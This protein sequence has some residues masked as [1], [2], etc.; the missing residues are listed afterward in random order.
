MN[1]W[2]ILFKHFDVILAG[3]YK[4][5]ILF[6]VSTISAGIIGIIA[7]FLLE[8]DEK[9]DFRRFLLWSIDI[10]RMLPFLI[11]VYLLYYGLPSLGVRMDAWTVGLVGLALY[12]GAY[13][14]EILRGLR[15]TLPRGQIDAAL[16][17]GYSKNKM[18][19]YL[20]LPQ[21]LLKSAPLMGNQLIYL[22]KDTA[23]LTIITV[24]ELTGAAASVQSIY[25]IPFQAFVVAI[26]F[27]WIVSIT[28]E[29]SM[30]WV[31]KVAIKRGIGNE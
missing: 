14:A 12:H 31:D 5:L 28:I 27:Y 19:A 6:G 9:S 21:L 24:Q 15:A 1:K 2:D 23:F 29:R 13:V 10:M 22:L 18:L 4:T 11:F 7:L 26:A 25:F 17:H 30:K 20:V 3:F 16:A 8:R